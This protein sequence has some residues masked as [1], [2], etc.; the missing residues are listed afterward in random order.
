MVE[1][2]RGG[3]RQ[4]G[5]LQNDTYGGVSL[6]V[7]PSWQLPR[8]RQPSSGRT[9]HTTYKA[10]TGL[11]KRGYHNR[12]VVSP[13]GYKW[14]TC[15]VQHVLSTALMHP[16][17]HT[18]RT[19]QQPCLAGSG[20]ASWCRAMQR[21]AC[22][23]TCRQAAQAAACRGRPSAPRSASQL[24]RRPGVASD[25]IWC[26]HP[27]C[28]LVAQL[29]HADMPCWYSSAE[30]LFN[31]HIIDVPAHGVA[32]VMT[33]S[34]QPARRDGLRGRMRLMGICREGS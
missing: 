26:S 2:L 17:L 21:A 18:R 25:L 22:P 9:G 34:I 24:S 11:S 20:Q 29:L 23:G 4:A 5:W 8:P 27:V 19:P 6:E 14:G 13:V 16:T 30:Y 15:M 33:C 7:A 12:M 28:A 3:L 1:H 31:I 32:W 10:C